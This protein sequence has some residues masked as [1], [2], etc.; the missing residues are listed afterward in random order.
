M[1]RKQHLQGC[2]IPDANFRL[3]WNSSFLEGDLRFAQPRHPT[4]RWPTFDEMNY[5]SVLYFSLTFSQTTPVQTGGKG[6]WLIYLFADRGKVYVPD[7]LACS[8]FISIST[9][10]LLKWV[11][12]PNKSFQGFSWTYSVR[13][14]R[15]T[16]SSVALPVHAAS[17]LLGTTPPRP[18]T[19][20][21][22]HQWQS[23]GSWGTD[24]WRASS[25][26]DGQVRPGCPAGT[27]WPP[28]S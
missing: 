20:M 27:R 24:S 23:G 7:I 14:L 2:F 15:K 22:C 18:Q 21:C 17:K 10:L 3:E 26:Y 13:S 8:T 4:F 12:W 5:M 9:S 1:E 11:L 25:E 28:F 16:P 6:D 19:G